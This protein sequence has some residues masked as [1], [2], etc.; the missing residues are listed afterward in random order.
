MKKQTVAFLFLFIVLFS[1]FSRADEGMWLPF[2]LG[3]N[4]EDMKKH[5][6]NLI[7]EEIYSINN[8]FIKD[9]IVSFGGFCT[10][11]V[12]SKKGLLLTNHY[13]GYDVI[14][15]A[16]TAENNY[17]DDGFW[18]KSHVEEIVIPGLI[19]IFVVFIVDVIEQITKNL[20]DD[21]T[22]EECVM[23]IKKI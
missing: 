8:S 16:L 2:L 18:A 14:V 4:Y 15:E 10:A 3:R 7:Q 21:M 23:K 17:L 20:T 6:L 13:C 19:A 5:G 11:E 12:I 1:G 9:V 22:E